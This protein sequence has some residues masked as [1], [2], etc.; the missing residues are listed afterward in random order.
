MSTLLGYLATAASIFALCTV[1][2]ML[3][4]V[5]LMLAM[6]LHRPD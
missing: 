2:A 3:I 6:E 4:I 1:V 5:L